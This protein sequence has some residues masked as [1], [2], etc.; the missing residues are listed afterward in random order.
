MQK[1]PN[2]GMRRKPPG[3]FQ[4]PQLTR[5]SLNKQGLTGTGEIFHILLSKITF[6]LNIAKGFSTCSKQSKRDKNN[7]ILFVLLNRGLK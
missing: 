6:D 1:N 7:P 4:M 2:T 5:H 3:H